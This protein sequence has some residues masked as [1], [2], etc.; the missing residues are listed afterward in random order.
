MK[1]SEVDIFIKA[2]MSK[3]IEDRIENDKNSKSPII[4][5]TQGKQEVRVYLH[6]VKNDP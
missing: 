3:P 5:N 2:V 1:E 6:P 4:V